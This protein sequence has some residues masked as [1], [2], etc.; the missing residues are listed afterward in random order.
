MVALGLATIDPVFNALGADEVTLPLIH[1]YMRIYYLGSVFLVV[2]MIGNSVLRAT[3]DAKVPA[4]TMTAAAIMNVVLDPILIFGWFGI[5]RLELQGAALASVIANIGTLIVSFSVIYFREH[6]IRFRFVSPVQILDSWRRILHVAI[7]SMTSSLV[8]PLTPAFITFQVARFGQAAVAGYGL[9]SRV[10]GLS[11]LA[12]MALGGAT[13][14]F[15]GQNFGAKLYDRVHEGVAWC[16]RFALTYGLAV[17]ALLALG[18]GVIAGL[19][20]GDQQA[21]HAANL[22]MRIVPISYGLL[23]IAMTVN[24]S[25]NAIGKPM[26]AMFVSLSR[27]L[28]VYVPLAWILSNLVG[29]VGIFIAAATANFVSGGVGFLWF[30]NAFTNWLAEEKTVQPA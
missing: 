23:G 3:G 2:P 15:V 17:A 13:T 12:L 25:F 16:Y 4:I 9:A 29:L 30:R 22:H 28:L 26:A 21:I 10:E 14:P 7:P 1:D 18:S 20:T 11:L 5:P 6:L 19:F 27:T 24:G 8:A